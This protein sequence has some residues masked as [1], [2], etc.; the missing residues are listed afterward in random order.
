MVEQRPSSDDGPH[1]AG[2]LSFEEGWTFAAW[3]PDGSAG[4][5]TTFVRRPGQRLGW[6]WALV[7]RADE[8]LVAAVDL[9]VPLR[10][11]PLLV[12]A[13]GL[14]AEHIIE[15]PFEQWTVGNE[16]LAVALAD[17]GDLLGA[18]YGEAVPVACDLEFYAEG[19]S[20]P[21]AWLAPPV[22]GDAY[23]QAGEVHG[24][25]ELEGGPWLFDGVPAR[26]AHWWG[27]VDWRTPWGSERDDAMIVVP[28]P[29]GE[30]GVGGT[31]L[32]N[33]LGPGGWR[34]STRLRH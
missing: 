8:P 9:A 21:P 7:A 1:L 14:W 27:V 29:L 2:G 25:V 13:E 30:A 28:V 33:A 26:R 5:L 10:S 19:P 18:G 6:Y 24:V 4:V 15:A 11:D 3:L 23:E 20:E 34:C 17:P 12:K 31:V 16:A 22:T 32:I